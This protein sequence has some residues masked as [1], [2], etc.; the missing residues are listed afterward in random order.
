MK[1]GAYSRVYN[2]NVCFFKK[3][4]ILGYLKPGNDYGSNYLTVHS[5]FTY[6]RNYGRKLG[7]V[8]PERKDRK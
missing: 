8:D 2:L 4:F 6:L 3:S 7:Q 1:L 5:Y